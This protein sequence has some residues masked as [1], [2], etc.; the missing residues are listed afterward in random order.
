MN[1]APVMES[2]AANIAAGAQRLQFAGPQLSGDQ[3]CAAPFGDVLQKASAKV[4]P[5]NDDSESDLAEPPLANEEPVEEK[6]DTP[7]MDVLPLMCFCPP[8]E[9]QT[10]PPPP[11]ATTDVAVETPTDAAPPPAIEIKSGEIQ[12]ER[13]ETE[14]P[15]TEQCASA[16]ADLVETVRP[17]EKQDK[18]TSKLAAPKTDSPK[19]VE[20]DPKIFKP[21]AEKPLE[22]AL[23]QASKAPPNLTPE[24]PLISHGTVVAQLGNAM[25]NGEK[26]AESSSG[27]EQKMPVREVSRRPVLAAARVDNSGLIS[28]A[29]ARITTD[30][31]VEAPAETIPVKSLAAVH[32]VESIRTEVAHLRQ[33]GQATMSLVLK[34]DNGTEIKV[35]VSIARDG[36]IQAQAR[37][38]RGDFQTLNAQWPQLQQS[39]AAHGIQMTNLSNTGNQNHNSSSENHG[40]FAGAQNFD[41]GNQPQNRQQQDAHTFEEE[42]AATT[43]RFP[44]PKTFKPTAATTTRRWQSWA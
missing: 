9:I 42:L 25:K 33:I 22:T 40:Q 4:A 10:T 39:L 19:A 16:S 18:P 28:S 38:D 11:P 8:P 15:E 14:L 12:S 27:I 34:P 36:T 13:A 23:P 17:K 20:L 29:P 35:D 7:T 37:C 6:K 3:D 32:L 30:F 21:I 41:R 1:S 31:K 26:T 24:P 5:E 2:P 44:T 43:P